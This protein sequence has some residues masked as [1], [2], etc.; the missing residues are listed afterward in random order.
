MTA[1]VNAPRYAVI[2]CSQDERLLPAIKAMAPDA[3]CLFDDPLDPELAA[4]A[5]WLLPLE[6]S[7]P[8]LSFWRL[9]GRGQSWGFV[10]ESKQS[11]DIV[12]RHLKKL[13]RAQLPDHSV[14]LFRFY[15]PRVLQMYLSSTEPSERSYFF[16]PMIRIFCED[17]MTG[18]PVT[19]EAECV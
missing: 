8:F 10:F 19:I 3:R 7:G 1:E 9:E 5:P 16:G 14:V 13:L 18:K 17:E 15:D 11:W 4:A 2:D 6:S 12:R